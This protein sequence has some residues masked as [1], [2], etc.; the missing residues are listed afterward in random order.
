M[1]IAIDLPN[2]LNTGEMGE[3]IS[4]LMSIPNLFSDHILIACLLMEVIVRY[5]IFFENHEAECQ[6][7]MAFFLSDKYLLSCYYIL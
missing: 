3:I 7:I 2:E 5:A 4:I 1:T 6:M